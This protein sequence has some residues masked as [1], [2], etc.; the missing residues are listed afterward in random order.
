[1]QHSGTRFRGRLGSAGLIVVLN[2]LFK[3]ENC[4]SSMVNFFKYKE[5]TEKVNVIKKYPYRAVYIMTYA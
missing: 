1:M 5:T 4:Y 3:P 2:Y